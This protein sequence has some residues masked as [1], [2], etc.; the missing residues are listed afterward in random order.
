MDLK[1]HIIGLPSKLKKKG[2]KSRYSINVGDIPSEK[3]N[4]GA[5]LKKV[6]KKNLDTKTALTQFAYSKFEKGDVCE[7]H[8]HSTMDEYFFVLSGG[9]VY[10]IGDKQVTLTKGD[11]IEIPAKTNHYLIVNHMNGL[12]LVYFGIKL[13]E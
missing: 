3:I 9:G 1:K 12:E 7:K 10:T 13:E 11:F 5:G 6:F 8:S 2:N 4:H